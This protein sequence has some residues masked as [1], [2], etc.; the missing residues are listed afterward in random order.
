M[1]KTELKTRDELLSTSRKL[2]ER[3]QKAASFAQSK[4]ERSKSLRQQWLYTPFLNETFKSSLNP[5]RGGSEWS[6]KELW[7]VCPAFS[8]VVN[9]MKSR[10]YD[11]LDISN[12]T[13]S[14]RTIFS[15]RRT[16]ASV[17]L[18][19][20]GGSMTT[21]YNEEEEFDRIQ[22]EIENFSLEGEAEEKD[23]HLKC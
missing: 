13:K 20:S 5:G 14:K 12:P 19:T 7:K 8:N 10:G 3:I 22:K 21:E 2:E 18:G 4:L 11:L 1:S 17:P 9:E 23:A 6:G 16:P 15:L